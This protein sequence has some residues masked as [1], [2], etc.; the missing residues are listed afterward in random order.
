[1]QLKGEKFHT[2]TL[3]LLLFFHASPCSSLVTRTFAIDRKP[4]SSSTVDT[5]IFLFEPYYGI[6]ISH[7]VALSLP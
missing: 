7:L 6:M 2:H 4:T 5:I 1:M 3:R